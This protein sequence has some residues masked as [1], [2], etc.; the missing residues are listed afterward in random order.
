MTRSA[1]SRPFVADHRPARYPSMWG[2]QTGSQYR[3]LCSDGRIRTATA[4]GEAD[5]FYTI[6]AR[7]SV[8][9]RT[10]SGHVYTR[11]SWDETGPLYRFS[12]S[13]YRKNADALP[14]WPIARPTDAI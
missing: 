10:V 3:V 12:A 5:T 11:E 13:S 2:G 4:T 6:P 14:A 1:D 7:L 8:R 9:G